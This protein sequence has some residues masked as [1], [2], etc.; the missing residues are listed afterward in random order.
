MV[1]E[2]NHTVCVSRHVTVL[3]RNDDYLCLKQFRK[4]FDQLLFVCIFW[5]LRKY[6]VRND[7]PARAKQNI[8][9]VKVDIREDRLKSIQ[10]AHFSHVR[11]WIFPLL[12]SLQVGRL[13]AE[14]Y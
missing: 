5:I 3:G 8:S 6:S 14:L 11:A 12:I 7:C 4:L 1:Y 13:V 9:A 2:A 10:S